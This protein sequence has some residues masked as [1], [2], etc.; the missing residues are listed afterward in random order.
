M[1]PEPPRLAEFLLRRLL[2]PRDRDIVTGDL[3]EEYRECALPERGWWRAQLWY[4]KQIASFIE[5]RAVI[6]ASRVIAVWLLLFAVAS[7]KATSGPVFHPAPA[8]AAFL[9][10]VPV[11]GLHWARRTG[12]LGAGM[13]MAFL[14]AGGMFLI[15]A[16]LW[17]ALEL[18]HPPAGA[19]FTPL[20]VVAALGMFGAAFGKRFGGRGERV[21]YSYIEV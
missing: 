9:A 1:N 16:V 7:A 6:S 18:R 20:A 14:T 8:V 17:R 3:F 10:I 19:W 4:W 5:W 21:G 13:I 11:A 12:S 15:G 2:P